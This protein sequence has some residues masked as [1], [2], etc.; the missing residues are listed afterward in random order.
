MNDELQG[1]SALVSKR[2]AFDREADVELEGILSLE[3]VEN[4][5]ALVEADK[6]QFLL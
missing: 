5:E 3:W 2:D 4:D 6:K 1:G